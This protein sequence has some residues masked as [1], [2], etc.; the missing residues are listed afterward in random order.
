MEENDT[1]ESESSESSESSSSEE[2]EEP[3]ITGAESG[4]EYYDEDAGSVASGDEYFDTGEGS[5]SAAAKL[6]KPNE[7]VGAFSRH[8]HTTRAHHLPAPHVA[9]PPHIVP[10]NANER[11][12][13]CLKC[14]EPN[15]WD[16]M[17]L[18][19][20]TKRHGENMGWF[21]YSCARLNP[22]KTLR[23]DIPWLCDECTAMENPADDP[24]EHIEPTDN[25]DETWGTYE[26]DN[27]FPRQGRKTRPKP[28]KHS[29]PRPFPRNDRPY[30]VTKKPRQGKDSTFKRKASSI[31]TSFSK[32]TKTGGRA[33]P[34]VW[35]DQERDAAIKLLG[36]IMKE[37][38][39][40]YRT[41]RRWQ[42]VSDRLLQRYNIVRTWVMVKNFWNRQGRVRSGVDERNK[43]NKNR[44]VTGVQ[45]SHTFHAFLLRKPMLT[46]SV[47]IP[48]LGDKQGKPSVKL[49]CPIKNLR[50]VD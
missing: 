25:E 7:Q 45:V 23:D 32:A 14:D 2:L 48:K 26:G 31:A 28:G 37:K 1:D 19:E 35:T 13:D 29:I 30:E 12:S 11:V 20:N 18:C 38:P 9:S 39:E 44:M 24:D 16:N 6:S 41:E 49:L 33:K 15:E 17:I 22:Y 50:A 46:S 43:P 5:S 4:V 40:G 42:I 27:L 10:P 34:I 21:H 8:D 3:P 47:R 36:E